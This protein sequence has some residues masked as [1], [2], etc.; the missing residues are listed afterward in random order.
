MLPK[1]YFSRLSGHSYKVRLLLSFLSV[2]YESI[3]LDLSLDEHRTAG[4]L[5]LN[6]LAQVPVW[7][8]GDTVLHDS[9]AI[10][11][12]LAHYYPRLHGDARW[13]LPT[14][15][16]QLGRVAQWLSFSANEITHSA[17]LVR[18]YWRKQSL[19]ERS[20]IDI[21]KATNRTYEVLRLLN[22][23]LEN[24][25]WLELG[26]PTI[27]DVAC[28][29]YISFLPDWNFDMSDY[30]AVVA[31]VKRIQALEGYIPIVAQA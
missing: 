13:S 3:L 21:V 12:Y 29:P 28:F 8:D 31:W 9:Q 17:T 16:A 6:P 15:S 20:D 11:V 1:L 27:A 10:L 4:F 24:R 22:D 18:A 30:P 2:G 25:E 5:A 23:H 19:G 26:R 14:E 7:Q